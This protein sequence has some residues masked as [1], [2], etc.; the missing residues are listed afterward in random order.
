MT[1][2]A[3]AFVCYDSR[4]GQSCCTPHTGFRD[5][6]TSPDALPR[7]SIES[8]HTS[9]GKTCHS[10]KLPDLHNA[11]G[12]AAAHGHSIC[13]VCTASSDRASE[14]AFKS[15]EVVGISVLPAVS[16]PKLGECGWH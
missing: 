7:Q 4:D 12:S 2:E 14:T 13:T 11:I 10:N 1:E 6:T 9:F 3:Y 5:L 8:E 16:V 15:Y